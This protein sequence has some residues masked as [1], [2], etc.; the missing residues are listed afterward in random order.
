MSEYIG[1]SYRRSLH[2]PCSAVD[3]VELDAHI[4]I[5]GGVAECGTVRS[6]ITLLDDLWLRGLCRD[7][8]AAAYNRTSN[9]EAICHLR[10]KYDAA[11][12]DRVQAQG[13]C[14]WLTMAALHDS[15]TDTEYAQVHVVWNVDN[16]MLSH[17]EPRS[18]EEAGDVVSLSTAMLLVLLGANFHSE[19]GVKQSDI[20]YVRELDAMLVGTDA[21]DLASVTG[22]ISKMVDVL[23][24]DEMLSTIG[25]RLLELFS[26]EFSAAKVAMSAAISNE[27]TVI[28]SYDALL[29][30][31]VYL[32]TDYCIPL[33]LT[34]GAWLFSEQ[35]LSD[36]RALLLADQLAG[37]LS[38][39]VTGW[40]ELLLNS[41]YELIESE[42]YEE[43][44]DSVMPMFSDVTRWELARKLS[45]SSAL[46]VLI[47]TLLPN[48]SSLMRK[49]K[50]RYIKKELSKELDK[51][52]G[53]VL[54]YLRSISDE[55]LVD[56]TPPGLDEFV[57]AARSILKGAGDVGHNS[58][59][60][61]GAPSNDDRAQMLGAQ[62]DRGRRLA[63]SQT[64]LIG[65]GQDWS[66]TSIFSVNQPLDPE[67]SRIFDM[68][69][70]EIA[71]ELIY[72]AKDEIRCPNANVSDRLKEHLLT[73]PARTDAVVVARIAV[74][75][76]CGLIVLR[77]AN[78]D[79]QKSL[80]PKWFE[81][82][83]NIV[84]GSEPGSLSVGQISQACFATT[85]Y[86]KNSEALYSRA[87][88]TVGESD[89]SVVDVL[90]DNIMPFGISMMSSEVRELAHVTVR[91]SRKNS[92]LENALQEVYRQQ[93][94]VF[95]SE[96][97]ARMSLEAEVKKI[98]GQSMKESKRSQHR[99]NGLSDLRKDIEAV[100]TQLA[101]TRRGPAS[102]ESESDVTTIGN[103]R[104]AELA[105][106]LRQYQPVIT[107]SM[108]GGHDALSYI[109]VRRRR[110]SDDLP[111]D[112]MCV[113]D[114]EFRELPP[115]TLNMLDSGLQSWMT[116]MSESMSM[117]LNR[118]PSLGH[119][120]TGPQ[121]L[122]SESFVMEQLHRMEM[123]RNTPMV[124]DINDRV[125]IV[126]DKLVLSGNSGRTEFR[127]SDIPVMRGL[128]L[129]VDRLTIDL[130][131]NERDRMAESGRVA[132][133]LSELEMLIADRSAIDE[134]IVVGEHMLKEDSGTV[135]IPIVHQGA[136]MKQMVSDKPV[137]SD[138]CITGLDSDHPTMGPVYDCE[139][140]LNDDGSVTIRI[141]LD[142]RTSATSRTQSW[143]LH[144]RNT[145]NS[146]VGVSA[147]G[148]PVTRWSQISDALA[149]L[150]EHQ[151]SVDNE[152]EEEVGFD[153]SGT[154]S[155]LHFGGSR[156]SL[157]L[158][159]DGYSTPEQSGLTATVLETGERVG[160]LETSAADVVVDHTPASGHK[161]DPS[162][163]F[164]M[165]RELVDLRMVD[166]HERLCSLESSGLALVHATDPTVDES[167]RVSELGV[168]ASSTPAGA[169]VHGPRPVD[170]PLPLFRLDDECPTRS[171]WTNLDTIIEELY[172]R[173]GDCF[174]GDSGIDGTDGKDGAPG[175]DFNLLEPSAVDPRLSNL[176][177]IVQELVNK[178]GD[179]LKGEKGDK[180]QFEDA[181]D[182]EVQPLS[183]N[184]FMSIQL[185]NGSE[186]KRAKLV[187]SRM[188][189]VHAIAPDI[190]VA[191]Q[192]Q[193]IG[194]LAAM[195][196]RIPPVVVEHM[197]RN[198]NCDR[199]ALKVRNDADLLRRMK[200]WISKYTGRPIDQIDDPE[201]TQRGFKR[202]FAAQTR[203]RN[204]A[205]QV[206]HDAY[207]GDRTGLVAMVAGV[208]TEMAA[209]LCGSA[210]GFSQDDIL[211]Y[212]N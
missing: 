194:T 156:E 57:D 81:N 25:S 170:A 169:H 145:S 186:N 144:R 190:D 96:I 80:G 23:D 106:E 86:F 26:T 54:N 27:W 90:F 113:S 89:R 203:N 17:I 183:E 67:Y 134:Q 111:D 41:F 70:Y 189:P 120:S 179:A 56:L 146:S 175:R 117:I 114:I 83:D 47:E 37:T 77:D 11:V 8:V 84:S 208:S 122:A 33:I 72:L 69:L 79:I 50:K 103:I 110:I 205:I 58:K 129:A 71:E 18:V 74:V 138:V 152:P 131:A 45:N 126:G 206:L 21:G 185:V 102:E 107:I 105:A 98:S 198:N 195:S 55:R 121:L 128:S 201:M 30:R 31:E 202:W 34:I 63:I 73:L 164:T 151:S 148:A 19:S 100:K 143:S 127:L 39:T 6:A 20:D 158:K 207:A 204:V 180:G 184:G 61:D 142:N 109:N 76:I 112:M 48:D 95:Q 139:R 43:V 211:G 60:T 14:F 141:V 192:R 12:V 135:N 66:K 123:V 85:V 193:I 149:T 7:V 35:T 5:N 22:T 97:A 78:P 160:R 29:E 10:L 188:E 46:P 174:R 91:L 64:P 178:H 212:G 62:D 65:S 177:I 196:E 150:S 75:I 124:P 166:I 93:T 181:F 2:R 101:E 154:E 16:E 163:L 53:I 176:D 119:D 3:Y 209:Y 159:P 162:D 15:S 147:D 140:L 125:S 49:A 200:Q 4:T 51:A 191:L 182:V 137:I 171:G 82:M 92:L 52:D 1:V 36:G 28:A 38:S 210:A 173:H 132:S 118:I 133:K 104:R 87:L 130:A 136:I 99:E 199:L 94:D 165:V 168:S 108:E 42:E 157:D 167:T 13:T 155:G 44:D 59:M 88:A 116:N 172:L 197:L 153:Q 187:V 32:S 68:P 9:Y 24:V 115:V 161:R 40:Q